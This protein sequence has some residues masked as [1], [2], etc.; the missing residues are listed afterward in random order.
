[1]NNGVFCLNLEKP[2]KSAPRCTLLQLVLYCSRYVDQ[3]WLRKE[4]G[5]LTVGPSK[6]Q[7][8]SSIFQPASSSS[9][10]YTQCF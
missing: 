9:S 7:L 8:W 5:V 3:L 4:R 6:T 1:M 10:S 2:S